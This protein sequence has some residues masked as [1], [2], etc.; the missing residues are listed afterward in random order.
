MSSTNRGGQRNPKDYYVTPIQP[1]LDFCKAIK[2]DLNWTWDKLW[3]LDPCAGGDEKHPMSYPTA[4]EQFAGIKM[5]TID[6]REDSRAQF[7]GDYITCN[8]KENDIPTP[9]VVMSNPPFF[10]AQEFVNKALTDVVPGGWVILLLRLNY[11]GAQK[12]L[13]WWHANMPVY[14]YVHSDRMSF[15][16]DGKTDSIEYAH[17]MWHQGEHPKYTQLR[18]I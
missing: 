18:V 15:T 2:E 14:C 7:V 16:E 6:I 9:D 3:V 1:I 17:C 11:F 5:T 4:L 12:R 13:A 8:L 10:L